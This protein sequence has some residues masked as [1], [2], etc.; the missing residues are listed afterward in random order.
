MCKTSRARATYD[1]LNYYSDILSLGFLFKH[2]S[3]RFEEILKYN[4]DIRAY[5]RPSL[6]ATIASNLAL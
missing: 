6:G 1:K 5:S 4:S 2:L 3:F